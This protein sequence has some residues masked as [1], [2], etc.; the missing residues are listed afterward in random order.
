MPKRVIEGHIRDLIEVLAFKEWTAG[1]IR[2]ELQR[3]VAAGKLRGEVP[4]LRTIQR[5]LAKSSHGPSETW[6]PEDVGQVEPALVLPVLAAVMERSGG[7]RQH[8]TRAEADRIATLRA[9]V[10]DLPE[11]SA[12]LLA[13]LY[14]ARRA[15]GRPTTDL[16]A[17]VAFAPWRDW[18]HGKRY[19]EG[20]AA[21]WF[22]AAPEFLMLML[23]GVER[24][25]DSGTGIHLAASWLRK[26]PDDV[27]DWQ[28]G[29]I[30]PRRMREVFT[31]AFLESFRENDD[32]RLIDEAD[33][34]LGPSHYS[35]PAVEAKAR[36]NLTK[37]MLAAKDIANMP[38][39]PVEATPQRGT[40]KEGQNDGPEAR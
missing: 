27:Q 11:W 14:L 19:F 23:M 15:Q 18:E 20:C 10:P 2:N 29:G 39:D 36:A 26:H 6:A 12:F 34:D 40:K 17:L 24:A 32:R 33:P 38:Q 5:H 7:R 16:D 31:E 37:E 30:T 35:L 3:Q 21:E 28:D 9:A 25:R 22:P 4:H 13:R 1:E 8:L